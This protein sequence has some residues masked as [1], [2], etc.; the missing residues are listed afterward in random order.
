MLS[1]S[2]KFLAGL[3]M[4]SGLLKCCLILHVLSSKNLAESFGAFLHLLHQGDGV[5]S[6]VNFR[7]WFKSWFEIFL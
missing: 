5:I 2:K 1:F 4:S 3:N 6:L 7:H